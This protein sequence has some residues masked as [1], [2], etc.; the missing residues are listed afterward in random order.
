MPSH[1]AVGIHR[2][3]REPIVPTTHRLSQYRIAV[4]LELDEHRTPVAGVLR[5]DTGDRVLIDRPAD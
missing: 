1:V 5:L 3:G 2:K 4:Q